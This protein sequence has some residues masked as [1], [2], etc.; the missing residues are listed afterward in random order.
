MEKG[1]TCFCE[2]LFLKNYLFHITNFTTLRKKTTKY[3]VLIHDRNYLKYK[4]VNKCIKKNFILKS[5]R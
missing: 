2:N 3:R 5:N 4:L 1:G